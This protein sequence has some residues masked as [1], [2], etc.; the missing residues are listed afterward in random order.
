MMAV[1]VGVA[2]GMLDW[3]V[4]RRNVG[5]EWNGYGA[6]PGVWRRDSAAPMRYRVLAAWV[7]LVLALRLKFQVKPWHYQVLK[8][9]LLV[10]ALAT[11]EAV[12]GTIG[13]IIVAL[14]VA[15]TLE[16]DYW[17]SYAE[18]LGAW[19]I[20][21]GAGGGGQPQGLPQPGFPL[22][23]IAAVALGAAVWGLSKETALLAPALAGLAAW[24]QGQPQGLPQPAQV[25]MA[26]M[27]G[28]VVAGLVRLVQVG[29]GEAPPRLYCER[30]TMRAYNLPD[31]ENATLREDVGPWLS[32][33]WTVAALAAWVW[34][35][36]Q[37][38]G[39]PVRD[40]AWV[41]PVWLAAGWL[42]ARARET[43]VFLPTALWMAGALVEVLR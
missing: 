25:I 1:L 7:L 8:T 30:W 38:Q 5:A 26:G 35:M 12:V 9:A 21:W 14:L 3:R 33:A 27:S 15:L 6:I 19:L 32:V 24:G 2:L 4:V 13:M 11:A 41:V 34:W 10:G 39:S 36:W 37:P 22:Q 42:M 23:A 18:M 17:S 29:R 20:V 16:Y 31:L 28:P 40:G 43:R